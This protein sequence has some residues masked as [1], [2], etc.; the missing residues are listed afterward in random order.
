MFELVKAGVWLMLPIL[1]C[2]IISAAICIERF[3]TLRTSQIM[4]GNLLAQVWSWI[5]AGEMDNQRLRELRSGSPLDQI[6]AAGIANH[7]RAA[8]K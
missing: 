2:S 3:W 5:K 1:L 8:I 4:P 7:R 6:L